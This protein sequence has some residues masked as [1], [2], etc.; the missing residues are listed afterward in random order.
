VPQRSEGLASDRIHMPTFDV[1]RFASRGS[2]D[3]LIIFVS[4]GLRWPIPIGPVMPKSGIWSMDCLMLVQFQ[5]LFRLA[6]IEL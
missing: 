4:S 6:K 1:D 3:S 2:G 5:D